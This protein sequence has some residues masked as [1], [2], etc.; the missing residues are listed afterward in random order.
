MKTVT[1]STGAVIP[2]PCHL[3]DRLLWHFSMI[4]I[5]DNMPEDV[6]NYLQVAHEIFEIKEC[7]LFPFNKN[8]IAL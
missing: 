6:R 8:R 5:S 7:I 3:S 4:D 2:S 1:L